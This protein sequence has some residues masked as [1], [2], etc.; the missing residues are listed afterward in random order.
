M[1]DLSGCFVWILLLELLYRVLDFNQIYL[2]YDFPQYGCASNK[3]SDLTEYLVSM[4]SGCSSDS[5][6]CLNSSFP[7]LGCIIANCPSNACDRS[8]QPSRCF[9]HRFPGVKDCVADCLT[10]PSGC[11][12][13]H[14]ASSHSRVANNLTHPSCRLHHRFTCLG[15]CAANR[16]TNPAYHLGKGGSSQG[17]AWNS[18]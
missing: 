13:K 5:N 7:C 9:H 3:L 6:N 1:S 4:L 8:A 10:H 14:L 18:L 2:I 11:L 12:Y 15:C 16:L 17:Q